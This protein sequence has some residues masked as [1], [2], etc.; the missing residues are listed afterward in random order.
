MIGDSSSF[1]KLEKQKGGNVS[2]V[3]IAREKLLDME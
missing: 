2:F 3:E 1:I